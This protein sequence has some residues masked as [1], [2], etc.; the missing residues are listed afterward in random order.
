MSCFSPNRTL[1]IL[2]LCFTIGGLQGTPDAIALP[3]QQEAVQRNAVQR[4][5][6]HKASAPYES[7][8]N[9]I[10]TESNQSSSEPS[11]PQL[12]EAEALDLEPTILENSPVLQRWLEEVPDG[13]SDIEHDP[14]FRTRLRAGYSQ[15]WGDRDGGVMVGIEDIFV[16]RTGLTLSGDYRAEFDGDADQYGLDMR[17]YLLPLG[18]AVNV[19]PVLGYRQVNSSGT[20]DGETVEGANVGIRLHLSPSRSS[21]ADL[22]LTQTWIDPGS[23]RTLSQFTLSAGYALTTD[24]RLSTDVQIQTSERRSRTNVGLLLEWLL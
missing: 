15:G 19:S 8:K 20:N 21:A 22:S 6:I 23:D 17:Y 12:S 4:K 11:Q 9:E 3:E 14:S 18:K 5:S 24:V 2:A 10:E 16:G 7:L 1:L 13:L